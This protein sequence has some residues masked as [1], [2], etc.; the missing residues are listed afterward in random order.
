[1]CT[2]LSNVGKVTQFMG[3]GTLAFFSTQTL[4]HPSKEEHMST[5]SDKNLIEQVSTLLRSCILL[6]LKVNPGHCFYVMIPSL[7]TSKLTPVTKHSQHVG[8]LLL[9]RNVSSIQSKK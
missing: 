1:M 5:F 9:S 3:R 7:H 6:G 8:H 4:L 2:Y